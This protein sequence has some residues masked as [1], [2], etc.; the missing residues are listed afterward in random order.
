MEIPVN[1]RLEILLN[2]FKLS[3]KQLAEKAGLSENTISNAKKGKNV[4]GVDFFNAIYR[5]F[6]HINPQWLYM[7][8][9]NMFMDGTSPEVLVDT[10]YEKDSLSENIKI[11]NALRKEILYLQAQIKDK[12]EIINLLRSKIEN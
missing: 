8:I 12:E 1:R 2:Y 10:D 4:P 7:G 11:I 9:G 5:A 3:Q 6:P